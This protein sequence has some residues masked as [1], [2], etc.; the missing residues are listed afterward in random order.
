M[1]VL[2]QG[3]AFL[4]ILLVF[5]ELNVANQN[6]VVVDDNNTST[7]CTISS[8]MHPFYEKPENLFYFGYQQ[9]ASIHISYP[10][11]HTISNN[12]S[13]PII[14]SIVNPFVTNTTLS[15]VVVV[16]ISHLHGDVMS[17][18]QFPLAAFDSKTPRITIEPVVTHPSLGEYVVK[19][20]L[21]TISLINNTYV[22]QVD[23]A[24]DT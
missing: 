5:R 15:S 8:K 10:L 14:L 20:E 13:L 4:I 2:F 3:I 16:Q 19:A 22:T 9:N 17:I 11:Y 1:S 21:V 18:Q 12:L 24:K 7:S 6:S 23:Y